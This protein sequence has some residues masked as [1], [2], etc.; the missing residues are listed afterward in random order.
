M[1]RDGEGFE[2]GLPGV[3]EPPGDTVT[4]ESCFEEFCAA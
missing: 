4:T 1:G 2:V 3:E